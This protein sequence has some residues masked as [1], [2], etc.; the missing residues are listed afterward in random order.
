MK[1]PDL[2]RGERLPAKPVQKRSIENGE[3]LKEAALVLFGELGYERTSIGA[4]AQKARLATGGFYLHFRSKRQLLLVLM[5]ELLEGLSRLELKPTE[6]GKRAGDV[7]RAL[8]GML[9]I[10]F[11]HDLRYLGACRAWQEAALADRDL[12]KKQEEIHAWSTARTLRL[13]KLLQ[14]LPGARRDVDMTGVAAAIDRFF[15]SL[16]AQASGFSRAQLGRQIDAATHLIYHAM[17]VDTRA[18]TAQLRSQG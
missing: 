8:R 16:L 5:D 13:L 6:A 12:Q 3:R 17:F 2:L 18:S 4:I 9:A 1:R 7:P 10:A 11:S 14:S 15:W